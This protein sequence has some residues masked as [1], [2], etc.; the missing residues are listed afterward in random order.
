[1]GFIGGTGLEDPK[2]LEKFSLH[3]ID[4]PYGKPS[5]PLVEG[6]IH[7]VPV[8]LLARHGKHHEISPTNV[9]YRANIW[10]MKMLGNFYFRFLFC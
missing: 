5:S 3:E 4:T 8:V 7:G 1:M 9:N 10:A 2:L 6:L